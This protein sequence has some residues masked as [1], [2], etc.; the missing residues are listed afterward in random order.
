MVRSAWAGLRKTW[1]G[2][3][4][5]VQV[6]AIWPAGVIKTLLT[7]WCVVKIRRHLCYMQ[8]LVCVMAA[9]PSSLDRV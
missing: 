6:D 4:L 7:G 2:A 9:F 5:G 3:F 1:V 8:H